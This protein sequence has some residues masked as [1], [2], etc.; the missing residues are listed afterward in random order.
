MK[1]NPYNSY[2]IF[3]LVLLRVL[4]GWHLLYE[5]VVKIF[6]SSWSAGDFLKNS[7]GPLSGFFEHLASDNTLLF[8]VDLCNEWGLALIGLSLILGFFT[9]IGIICGVILLSMYYMAN[10]PFLGLDPVT[11]V[12]GSYLIVNKNLIEIGAL[13]VLSGFRSSY[14]YGLDRFFIKR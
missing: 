8:A 12:E 13:L 6:D 3:S 1:T 10:P 9:R 14:F 4:I 7:Q 5:G 2:Q 11:N